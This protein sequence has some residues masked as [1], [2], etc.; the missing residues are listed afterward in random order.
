MLL[1]PFLKA[2]PMS[3]SPTGKSTATKVNIDSSSESGRALRNP[4]ALPEAGRPK[5]LATGRHAGDGQNGGSV[6]DTFVGDEGF[7]SVDSQTPTIIDSPYAEQFAQAQTSG[8]TPAAASAPT[9][10]ASAVAGASAVSMGLMALGGLAII[11][12][13]GGSSAT[14]TTAPT[15]DTTAPAAP[16]ISAVA[17]DNMVNATEKT[18]GVS[19][20][21]TAEANASV[22]VSW[23][24]I[25]KTVA[26][27]ASGAWTTSFL[28]SEMPV[29]AASTS[30]SATATDAAGNTSTAGTRT[31]AVDTVTPAVVSMTSNSVGQT[32]VLTYDS[33][34][35]GANAPPVSAFAVTTGGAS[36]PV[37]NASVSGKAL[38]LT[39][40]NAFGKVSVNVVYTDPTTGNDALAIQDAAGNDAASFTQ[41]VVADGYV[42]GAQIFIE[43]SDGTRVNTGQLTDASGNFF[44]PAG[45]P[46]GVIVAR[47]GVNI[48]TGVPNT[49]ELKAPAG[50]TT[51]NPLTTLVQAVV[52]ATGMSAA[53]AATTVALNLGLTLPAGQTLTSYDPLTATDGGAVTAQKAAAQVATL[54]T[55]AAG[56]D[57]A[58]AI[59]VVSNLANQV[60]AANAVNRL[61][62]TASTTLT[63]ALAGVA[64]T[65]TQQNAIAD[66]TAAI[67]NA[68]N[69][70]GISAAQGQALDKVA[71]AAPVALTATPVTNDTTPAVQI[72]LNTTAMDGTA[73]VAGD[74]VELLSH[75]AVVGSAVLTTADV[76]AGRVSVSVGSALADDSYSLAARV[77]DQAG[78]LGNAS[79]SPAM[80]TVDTL[81]PAAP[82]IMTVA[83]D[84][85]IN[86]SEQA[87]TLT[88]HAEALASVSLTIGGN[89]RVVTANNSGAWSYTLTA[90]DMTAMG[91]GDVTLS[92][93]ATDAA[94]NVSA[95]GSRAIVV[96][97]IAPPNLATLTGAQD[98][99]SP[100]TG[101]VASAGTTNDNTLLLSG[102]L[103]IGLL[104]SQ[105]VVVYDGSARL[106]VAT[107]DGTTWNF[108]TPAL[109][110]AVHSFTAVVEDAAGNQGAASTPYTVT[111]NADVPIAT[112]TLTAASIAN[113]TTPELSGQITGTLASG[114]SVVVYDAGIRLGAATLSGNAWTFTPASAL[115]EGAHRFTAVVENT[116]GNQGAPSAAA[117]Q[118]IDTTAPLAPSINAVAGDNTINFVE[119][120]A[121]ISGTAEAGATVSLTLGAGNVRT[122]TASA[123]GQWSYTPVATDIAAM[124]QGAETVSAT[125]TDTAAN[126]GAAATRNVQIDTIAPGAPTINL[127]DNVNQVNQTL[128]GTVVA[129]ATVLITVG[130]GNVRSASVNGSGEWLYNLTATD[131][132]VMGQ[133]AETITAVARDA[134]GNISTAASINTMVDTVAPLLTPL[135]LATSS[136]SGTQGDGRSN[137]TTPTIG[138]TADDGALL[139]LSV[140]GSAFVNAGSPGTGASQ[141]LTLPSAITPD[142]AYALQLKATDASG[143]TTVRSL[144]YTLDTTAAAPAIGVVTGD[145]RINA[146]ERAGTVIVQGLAEI[147][148]SVSV[149]LGTVTKTATAAGG[150]WQ[151]SFAA[152]ELPA[153]GNTTVRATITDLAGNASTET[154]H[155]VVVDTVNP[156]LPVIDFVAGNNVVNAAEKAGNVNVTGSAEANASVAVA[157]GNAIK[158][159]ATDASGAWTTSFSSTEVP[160][161]AASSN[162]LATATD[163]AGNTGASATRA[164]SIDTSAPGTPSI[165]LVATDNI[166]NASEKSAGISV[167]GTAEANASVTVAWVGS[168]KTIAAS[169]SG[170]WTTSFSGTE[171]PADAV[172]TSIVAT[173]TDA[174]GNVSQPATHSVVVDTTAP[175]LSA[176]AIRPASDSGVVGDSLSKVTLPV[177]EF[178]AGSGAPLF[179]S[180]DGGTFTPFST[181]DGSLQTFSPPASLNADGSYTY[182]IRALDV[183][184]NTTTQS[185]TY[186]LDTRTAAP[187]INTVSTDNTVNAAEKTAGVTVTGT[188]EANASVAVAWGSASKTVVSGEGGTWTAAFSSGE[189][190]AD[191]STNISVTA[192]DVAGNVSSSASVSVVIDSSAPVLQSAVVNGSTLTLTYDQALNASQLPALNQLM[193]HEEGNPHTISSVSVQGNQVYLTLASPVG[194]Q[195]GVSVSYTDLTV[196]DDTYAI[197][198]V[199]GNDVQGVRGYLATNNTSLVV[200]PTLALANDTGSNTSDG[201]TTDGRVT[202]GNLTTGVAWDYSTDGGANWQAGD[203]SLL[204]AG[205]GTYASGQI[206]VRQSGNVGTLGQALTVDQ[207]GPAAPTVLL[208]LDTGPSGTDRLTSNGQIDVSGLESGASW[209]YTTNGGTSWVNGTGSSFVLD[210]GQYN[211]PTNSNLLQVRQ[212]DV[213]GNAGTPAGFAAVVTIDQTA[214]RPTLA[215]PN[216][217][218]VPGDAITSNGTVEVRGLEYGATWQYSTTNGTSWV[219]GSGESLTLTGSGPKGVTVRQTDQAGNLSDSSLPLEFT[220]DNQPPT[221]SSVVA[222][223][224]SVTLTMSEGVTSNLQA[225]QFTVMAGG[226]LNIPVT[227]LTFSG[228]PLN[229]V[230]LN[231]QWAIGAGDSVTLA[232]SGPNTSGVVYPIGLQDAAGN[233]TAASTGGGNNQTPAPA[234]TTAP[235]VTGATVNGS[236]LTLTFSESLEANTPPLTTYRSLSELFTVTV[237]GQPNL[238][239]GS[240]V[241]NGDRMTLMLTNPVVA[242][243]T[244]LISYADPTTANDPHAVQDRTGNDMAS[245]GAQA[246]TNLA[247]A[248][249]FTLSLAQTPRTLDEDANN[250]GRQVAFNGLEGGLNVATGTGATGEQAVLTSTLSSFN[251]GILKVDVTSGDSSQMRLGVAGASGVFAVDASGVV[252]YYSDATYHGSTGLS[253]NA[254]NLSNT[255][256]AIVIGQVVDA[257]HNG[258]NGNALWITLNANATPDITELL[259]SH[260]YL[261]V[262]NTAD[263]SLTQD[264]AATVGS[265]TVQFTLTDSATGTPVTATREMNVISHPDVTGVSILDGGYGE[266]QTIALTVS[267]DEAMVVSGSPRFALDI[268]GVTKYA[269]YA[270]G[271]GTNTLT[272]NYTVEAGLVDADGIRVTTPLELNGGSV[273]GVGGGAVSVPASSATDFANVRV[274]GAVGPIDATAPTNTGASF[275]EPASGNSV[276]TLNFSET[277]AV[278]QFA[279]FSLHLNPNVQDGNGGWNASMLNNTVSVSG[280]NATL[281]LDQKLVA[282]DV[283]RVHYYADTYSGGGAS[284]SSGIKDLSGNAYASEEIWVGG[285]AANA[286][287]LSQYGSNLP[288]TLRGNG[289]ADTL[290][291][292]EVANVL[293][294]GGGSDTLVGGKGADT[295][296][297]V[298]NGGVNGFASYARDTVVIHLGDSTLFAADKV[299]GSSAT[300]STGFDAKSVDATQHDV[301]S[302]PSSVIAP[303]A[304]LDGTDVDGVGSH[305]VTSGIA[306]FRDTSGASMTVSNANV[307]AISAYLQAN[308]TVAGQTLAFEIDTDNNGTTDALAVVQK[309]G[310]A[311]GIVLPATLVVLTGVTNVTLGNASGANVLQIVDTQAPDPVTIHLTTSGV[312]FSFSETAF[313]TSN[314][315]MSLQQNG[316]GT[317]YSAMIVAGSGSTEMQVTYSGLTLAN[318]DWALLTYSGNNASNA[319]S[320]ALGNVSTA[321]EGTDAFVLGSDGANTINLSALSSGLDVQAMGGNDMVTGTSGNDW[322]HGGVGADTLTGG[323]GLDHF[324]FAQG[325]S[326]AV[327]ANL[328]QGTSKTALDNG[329]TF[330]F[331][332][333]QADVITDF[334]SGEGVNLN[335]VFRDYTGQPGLGFMD[336]TAPANGL[337]LDQSFFGVTGSFDNVTGIF[338]VN[339]SLTG[340][341]ADTLVVYDGDGSNAI[342][343]T[344]FVLEGVALS[345]LNLLA[346]NNYISHV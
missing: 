290:K 288:I 123:S 166:V 317:A 18:A 327:T 221:F 90:A 113:D 278:S 231:L 148:A 2:A 71:P 70:A 39:L 132:S 30:I 163:A 78:K 344:A 38:T 269:L 28:A 305:S 95:T 158:T 33:P 151:V 169:S 343:Q 266:G 331:A 89:V 197:Q 46:S 161:D 182:A 323:S 215:L 65:A 73:A 83:G 192:T 238:I 292:T 198:D 251:G 291:G 119:Q 346:G 320:D 21:G 68:T 314:L 186:T 204:V 193:V 143:N 139:A 315:A 122:V 155:T 171:V 10:A 136:D 271:S 67:S 20:S 184:G 267:A 257:S 216:D 276:I 179:V 256:A 116:G 277:V 311:D 29:D 93:T 127:L 31:V 207:T 202:V 102:G 196:G 218:G 232:Y 133:G 147:G 188:A 301:L 226:V 49:L 77:V 115:T 190:P 213:A 126:T 125:A 325:D 275:T 131:L 279:N 7:G 40:A 246:V 333:G 101:N 152:N 108:A 134:A 270:S 129:G 255:S 117:V 130:A 219:D 210:A 111:V 283:V 170:V 208:A 298:E 284:I 230:Q 91:S 14:A 86:A 159:V 146:V 234:D 5:V 224:T 54:I 51:I 13:A 87:T 260:I 105:K 59:T 281:T 294:D 154:I 252:T 173:A 313:A 329:D 258:K 228:L 239:S 17:T 338:T 247:A 3:S 295:I 342:A 26:A 274:T 282:T 114:D 178:T 138:F 43:I 259:V 44:L 66:A 135:A 308:F 254:H 194:Y 48:D 103:N 107:A 285:S 245:F 243:Q 104:G 206:Q 339:S 15:K 61:D 236:T 24:T 160:A 72:S 41:G 60:Q 12:L 316:V 174:A 261:G 23:G 223:G 217:T 92:A 144:S 307:Q 176:L 242:G 1:A 264:W 100:T 57:T 296:H 149:T 227:S 9:A 253:V 303:N 318:N 262:T 322:I 162:I 222:N 16:V 156:A 120:T 225:S 62:L 110:N 189:V 220:L 63:Q 35:D 345:Q 85:T 157:W 6:L 268:G 297:L 106:G 164:V 167:S 334:I 124:G 237:N 183:A 53:V 233:L 293:V 336:R 299:V 250:S 36:N 142:G 312:A 55:L 341:A 330:N 69:L 286:I 25:T 172:S 201:I 97:L 272:F 248:A 304:A 310:V 335:A 199:A 58:A 137:D 98:N 319:L 265:K 214:T 177:I 19:I 180:V 280:S 165:N 203:K 187:T 141:T 175:Y 34:L 112:A 42:R 140:N 240:E 99:V 8:A 300:G 82:L 4:V 326:T 88:G 328:T 52:A 76:A 212:V 249:N 324:D 84:D 211:T 64:T 47:G 32:V 128:T 27:N 74:R 195:T 56:S 150:E 287:D 45:T 244:V 289:G 80:V 81:A 37:T 75:G 229:V 302:L 205:A 181:G 11:G 79:A 94:G 340:S 321:D 241:I 309:T 145:D 263:T 235:T 306:T 153:D 121:T 191:G 200:L 337:A 109:G 118:T 332:N 273:T 185:I 22:A 50:S 168:S 96:D 209:Q